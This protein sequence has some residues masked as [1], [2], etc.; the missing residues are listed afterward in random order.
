MAIELPDGLVWVMDLLGLNWPQVNEDRVREFAGHVKEFASNLEKSHAS[1]SD[2]LKQMGEHYQAASYEQL[3]EKWSKM[4]SSHMTELVEVCNTAASV[5]EVAAV[6]IVGAKVAVIAELVVM[7]AEFIAD[8]AAAVFTLGL[9]EAAE[10][11]LIAATKK[12]VDVIL[13]EVE[14]QIVGELVQQATQPLQQ[15][16]ERAVSGLVFQGAEKALGVASGG[17]DAGSGYTIHPDE[18]LQ[19]AAKFRSHA[20]D[21]AGHAA[22]FASATEGMSFS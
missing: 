11:A 3:A 15:A 5:L 19:H 1:A 2:T 13:K 4:S 20:E 12:I 21:V 9:A 6:A 22:K 14:Q 7:A 8:Q 17:G 16:V 10:V 18:L